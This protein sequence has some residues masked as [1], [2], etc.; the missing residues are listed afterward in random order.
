[1]FAYCENNPI[2]SHDPEGEFPWV[3]LAIIAVAGLVGGVL[4]WNAEEKLGPTTNADSSTVNSK[5]IAKNGKNQDN[6]PRNYKAN[7]NGL[8]DPPLSTRDRITNAVIGASVGVA[9]AG[10]LLSIGGAI[11]TVAAGATTTIAA[12]GATGPQVFAIGALAYNS[13]AMFVAPFVGVEMEPIEVEPGY[14]GTTN[15]GIRYD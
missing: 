4:G 6:I 12:F 10:A 5:T 11:G 2:V 1:M 7:P 13:V 9:S 14:D 3:V 8:E 15:G